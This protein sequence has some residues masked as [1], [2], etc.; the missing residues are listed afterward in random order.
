MTDTAM[1]RNT[2]VLVNCGLFINTEYVCSNNISTRRLT[3]PIPV[4][5]VDGTAN[6]AGAVRATLSL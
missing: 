1:K 3:T 2:N 5:N 4:Y 6:E